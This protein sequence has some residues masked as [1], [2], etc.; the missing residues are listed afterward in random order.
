LSFFPRVLPVGEAAVTVELGDS[1]DPE[2]NARV[3]A[4]DRALAESSFPGFREAV[5]TYRSLLVCYDPNVTAF[6]GV[7][8]ALLEREDAPRSPVDAPRVHV[9]P[10]RYGGDDGPDL[11]AVAGR[12]GL[13]EA[14][15]VALHSGR[16]YTAFM[17]GFRP[18][19]AY[20]GLLP[21]AL[22]SPR[23]ASPRVHVPAGSVGIA[24]RQTGI[25]P[26]ASP[27]GWNLLAR[28][29]IPLFDA[30]AETP[31]LIQP[32][33]RVRFA[34]S[35]EEASAPPLPAPRI[36]RHRAAMEVLAGGLLTTVQDAGRPGLRRLGVPGAG[37]ADAQAHA[38]ANL[39]LG[40]HQNRAS[41]ECVVVGPTLRF[42]STTAFALAGADLGARLE[43]SDLGD[44][45]VPPGARVVARAGNILRFRGR[46]RGCR[47]YVAFEG[48]LD[49]PVVLGSRATDL[50]SGFGGYEG[51][52][53]RTGDRL[54]LLPQGPTR[55]ARSAGQS[56][57]FTDVVEARVVLGPQADSFARSEIAAFL[58]AAWTV[59]TASD[60]VGC[61]LA[62]P[63]LL[64]QPPE[65][66][67]D[68]MVPGCIQVPPSG[69]PI[70]MMADGPTTGGYPKIA[71]VIRADLPLLAQLLPGAGRV[72]F[73]A[74][75]V[76]TAPPS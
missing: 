37:P 70:V 8:A 33:D 4:L 29:F 11:S 17:L 24:G 6:A 40:N 39:A 31:T 58:G 63:R 76:E 10:A 51:R 53:L 68:G 15:V 16:E 52:A 3:R 32:G 45:P 41:L 71:C 13:G 38:C 47:A 36:S 49:V 55:A 60:R 62:G 56:Q 1:I 75:P 61:R 27:G 48:G 7:S 9:V 59:S 72:R 44:W 23:L 69:Q 43:R 65:I 73:R 2:V 30:Y 19:F 28:T 5:P 26:G 34:P 35:R 14:E 12:A 22:D 67:S 64:A 54:A 50:A 46:Q 21:P 57:M 18:G 42:L 74:I 20:L 25:Y 66:V